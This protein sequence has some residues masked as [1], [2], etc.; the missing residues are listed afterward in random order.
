MNNSVE[1]DELKNRYYIFYLNNGK[2]TILKKNSESQL[3]GSIDRL[4]NRGIE[5]FLSVD[6]LTLDVISYNYIEL[7]ENESLPEP[8]MIIVR[9]KD[10]IIFHNVDGRP[11]YDEPILLSCGNFILINRREK[12]FIRH[13]K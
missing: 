10:S 9:T 11:F 6:L 3:M 12:S 13:V 7:P 2:P 4:K 5:A 1:I 8:Y